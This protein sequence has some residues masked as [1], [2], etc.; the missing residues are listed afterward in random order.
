MIDFVVA[1]PGTQFSVPIYHGTAASAVATPNGQIGT[2]YEFRNVGGNYDSVDV[3]ATTNTKA[4]II[5]YDETEYPL[6]PASRGS[7]TQGLTTA[8]TT[9]YC[10]A[11]IEFLG[12]ACLLT[13]AGR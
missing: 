2:A 10:N 13:G 5:G 9:Q 3:S 4:V 12:S 11:W 8:G 6:W 7:T 1:E